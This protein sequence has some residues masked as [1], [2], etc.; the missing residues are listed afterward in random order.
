MQRKVISLDKDTVL[1]EAG[2]SARTIAVLE[3]GKLAARADGGLVGILWPEMVLG[4]SALFEAEG[5]TRTATVAAVQDDTVVAEYPP[6]V[7]RAAL[8]EG[9]DSLAQQ[10]LRTLIGQ[11]CRNFLMVIT[12]KRG[13]AFIEHPLRSLVR[14]IAEDAARAQPLKVWDSYQMTARTLFDLRDLS[15]RTL[16]AI[17]PDP[18]A[19]GDLVEQASGLLDDLFGRGRRRVRRRG[20]PQGGAGKDR[21]VGVRRSLTGG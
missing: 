6:A 18:A 2:D 17:G 5:S 20:L 14:G 16:S 3:K 21:L 9:D 12:A 4:E 11:I 10:I 13:Y 8:E 19:R 7:V 1:W 15:D